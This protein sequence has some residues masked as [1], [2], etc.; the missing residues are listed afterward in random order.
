MIVWIARSRI[1]EKVIL[2]TGDSR[3]LEAKSRVYGNFTEVVPTAILL[4][5]I[6]ELS[7]APLWAIH[8]MGGLMILSRICHGIGLVRPPGYGPLR[9]LGMLLAMAVF[10]IGACLCVTLG[11]PQLL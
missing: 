3:V 2:G 5:L 9:M 4:M 7:G 1:R 6:A 8:W 10:V 11:L